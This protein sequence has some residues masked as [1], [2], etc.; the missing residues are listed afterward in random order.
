MGGTNLL[1]AGD[2]AQLHDDLAAD[3]R[4]EEVIE[5][6]WPTLTPDKVLAE[7]YARPEVAAF[8][9]DDA[10]LNGLRRPASGEGD[11]SVWTDA[12][13]P[14]WTNWPICWGSLTTRNERPPNA[15]SG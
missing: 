8:D 15:K 14:C 10:T 12:D 13:A 6:L 7:L 1:S 4:L 9:Y 2:R 11:E 5:S 3:P